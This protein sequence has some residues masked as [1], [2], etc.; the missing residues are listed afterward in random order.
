MDFDIKS[1]I[2]DE[3][4]SEFS[5]HMLLFA[6][7]LSG[8]FVFPVIFA[9]L[10]VLFFPNVDLDLL[11]YYA[12]F[13]GYGS[14]IGILFYILKKEKFKKIIQGINGNNFIVAII[15]T[16]ILYLSSIII[17]TILI[18]LFGDNIGNSNQ[19]TLEKSLLNYP[20]II[21][22]F[23]VIF[24]PIVEEFVFRF[25]IFRPLSKKNKVLAYIITVLF[26]A[27]IHFISS[28]GE[29]STN[30]E[31]YGQSMAYDM[32]FNDFKTL[33]IYLVGAFVLTLSYDMNK[34]ISTNILIHMLYNGIQFA[35]LLINKDQLIEKYQSSSLIFLDFQGLQNIVY[36]LGI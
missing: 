13:L 29:L 9:V 5:Q 23:S 14:Y 24:A 17:N 19:G 16:I 36:L 15:F 8:M 7:G 35:L 32:L 22:A 30:I 3:S 12:Y 18:L 21:F 33:P 25:S 10:L 2:E 4:V 28:F 6:L 34:N 27:G 11:N 26:F 31:K 20:L 1:P